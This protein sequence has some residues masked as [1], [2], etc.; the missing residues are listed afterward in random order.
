MCNLTLSDIMMHDIDCVDPKSNLGTVIQ[1]IS[2]NDYSCCVI[3]ARNERPLG[4][5][6]AQD[7]VKLINQSDL[8]GLMEAK[9]SEHMISPPFTLPQETPLEDALKWLDKRNINNLLITAD[10]GEILGIVTP[11]EIATAYSSIMRHRTENLEHT[12]IT[13]TRELEEMNRK[14]V[15]MSMVDSLTGLGNWRAMEIDIMRIHAASI[16]HHHCSF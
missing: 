14:L 2:N 4:I 9:I 8:T 1:V 5:I 10:D 6:T 13:R 12:I 15:T 7:L 11:A 16:R 3:A